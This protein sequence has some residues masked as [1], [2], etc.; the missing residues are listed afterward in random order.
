L[1]L[2]FGPL[3]CRLLGGDN[4]T[5][6]MHSQRCHIAV[7]GSCPPTPLSKPRTGYINSNIEVTQ[8]DRK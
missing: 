7:I 2:Q 6:Q 4:P 8:I 3:G 1:F 5:E